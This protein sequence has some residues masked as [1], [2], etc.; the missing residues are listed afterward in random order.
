MLDMERDFWMNPQEAVQYGIVSR[1]I[2]RQQD[3][4]S[5]LPASGASPPPLNSEA[6]YVFISR[7][8]TCLSQAA[9]E[10]RG[11]V[12]DHDG[13]PGQP[14]SAS[15]ERTDAMIQLHYYPST[16]AMAPHILLEE[17]GVPYR[18]QSSSIVT[19]NAHKAPELPQAQ[20]QQADPRCWSMGT[21]SCMES[22]A[23]SLYLV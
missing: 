18:A 21:W 17:M 6:R 4:A 2:E 14:P 3:L 16:A 13:W 19:K 15:L 1:I 8:A 10:P 5:G 7:H 22:A 9:V 20:S 23:I 12:E 11:P